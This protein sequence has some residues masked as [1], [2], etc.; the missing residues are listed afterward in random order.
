MHLSVAAAISVAVCSSLPVVALETF[1]VQS[2]GADHTGKVPATGAIQAALSAIAA[3]GG[4]VLYFGPGTYQSA[5]FNL[6]NNSVLLLD[7]AVL[8][9]VAKTSAQFDKFSLIPPLPSYGEGRDK[10][11]ND[12]NGRYEAFIGGQC[13][14]HL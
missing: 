10:L 9:S 5:P 7:H 3:A 2:F 13:C 1:A 8:A 4:G 6:T 12:L 11:P 14:K